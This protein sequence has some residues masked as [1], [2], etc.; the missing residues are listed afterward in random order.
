[1]PLAVR[2]APASF[3][4]I[5][6]KGRE[7][8][9]MQGHRPTLQTVRHRIG[10]LWLLSKSGGVAAALGLVSA[11]ASVT[12][13]E[14]PAACGGLVHQLEAETLGECGHHFAAFA[15]RK[16][17]NQKRNFFVDFKL[18]ELVRHDRTFARARR[19]VKGSLDEAAPFEFQLQFEPRLLLGGSLSPSEGVLNHRNLLK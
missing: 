14:V 12:G 17:I 6:G 18:I 8:K 16:A 2:A 19:W 11:F 4:A 10:A 5:K 9:A 15:G 13:A 7:G 1:M 3:G